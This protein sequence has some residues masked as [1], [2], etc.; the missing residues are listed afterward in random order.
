MTDDAIRG[1]RQSAPDSPET[2]SAVDG[3]SEVDSGRDAG[4][5]RERAAGRILVAIGRLPDTAERYLPRFLRRDFGLRLLAIAT[6]VLVVSPAFAMWYFETALYGIAFVSFWTIVL[7]FLGYCEMYLALDRLH[8][9]VLRMEREELD[10][11]FDSERVDEV[12]ELYG[13]VESTAR[14]L[15]ETLQEARTARE[16]AEREENRA[17]EQA[18]RAEAEREA[19]EG[20][21]ADLEAGATTCEATMRAVADGDLRQRIDLGTEET[22]MDDIAAA[23]ND[24]A[25]DLEETLRTTKGFADEVR[26]ETDAVIG[27][28]E[29]AHEQGETVDEM[30]GEIEAATDRQAERLDAVV[31]ELDELSASVEQVAANVAS[32]ADQS[33]A[34]AETCGEGQAVA[35]DLAEDL[36]TTREATVETAA[37]LDAL[38]EDIDEIGAVVGVIDDIAEQ[39]SMLA[40]NAAIEA[41]R[42]GGGVD[43]DSGD[44]FAVVADEVKELAAETSAQVDEIAALVDRVQERSAAVV[45]RMA[46]T[47]HRVDDAT[48]GVDTVTDAFDEVGEQVAGIDRNIREIREATDAGANAADAAVD[49]VADV[50]DDGERT[51]ERARRVGDAAGTQLDALDTAVGRVNALADGADTL[52][53]SLAYFETSGAGTIGDAARG[54][55]DD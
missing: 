13:A 12:G 3:G 25:T 14:S 18:D 37:E 22:A 55:A 17:Q 49:T 43:G 1:G 7:G 11:D 32:V 30:A 39:T 10:V 44:G 47:R 15:D 5:R 27:A 35:A 53:R 42:A 9:A 16:R 38:D 28:V 41:A 4:G 31:A 48:D 34:A 36:A 23:F 20:L 45:D 40:L 54:V 29:R 8:E 2:D 19:A 21:A 6:F 33:S 52:Q 50:A 26:T 24:L 51:V 46:D